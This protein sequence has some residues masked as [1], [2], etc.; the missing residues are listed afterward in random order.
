MWRVMDVAGGRIS[1]PRNRRALT[2]LRGYKKAGAGS[3][4]RPQ[5]NKK[6]REQE[7]L[8]W[9]WKLNKI[10]DPEW[11][12]P[13][14]AEPS[15]TD[16]KGRQ[17]WLKECV[18]KYP[19]GEGVF[20]IHCTC[21]DIELKCNI[22]TGGACVCGLVRAVLCGCGRCCAGVGAAPWVRA[23]ACMRVHPSRHLLNHTLCPSCAEARGRRPRLGDW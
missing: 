6:S 16:P 21:C 12:S 18:G 17:H 19:D 11:F 3:R 22:H 9:K 10:Q 4:P 14:A 2:A 23:T 7:R 8:R 13:T 20:F 5:S 1:G 15:G